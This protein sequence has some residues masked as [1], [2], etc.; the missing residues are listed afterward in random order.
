MRRSRVWLGQ[1]YFRDAGQMVPVLGVGNRGG[2]SKYCIMV[3]L[4][5]V[6]KVFI[7]F[8]VIFEPC[9]ESRVKRVPRTLLWIGSQGPNPDQLLH[10]RALPTLAIVLAI[11]RL[12]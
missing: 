7:R 8:K 6:L 1:R 9:R 4:P 5:Y 11:A 2:W 3:G 10:V 12:S